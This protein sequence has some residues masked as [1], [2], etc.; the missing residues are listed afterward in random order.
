MCDRPSLRN[1]ELEQLSQLLGCL[2]RDRISPG[3]ERHHQ[4]A[5]CIERHVAVHHGTETD[6]CQRGY[7]HSIFCLYIFCHIT[8]AVLQ[9]IPDCIQTVRPDSV[10]QLIFPLVAS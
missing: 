6:A 9:T 4:L 8:V 2:L 7:F 1:V 3:T 10:Y 5:C